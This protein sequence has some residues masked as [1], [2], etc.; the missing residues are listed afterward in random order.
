MLQV[1]DVIL[2]NI[3][4]PAWVFRALLLF[5]AAGLPFV[6]FFAW[7]FELTPE[8]LKRESEVD[9]ITPWA[10]KPKRMLNSP[11]TFSFTVDTGLTRSLKSAPGAMSRIRPS[12]G[13]KWPINSA[14]RDWVCC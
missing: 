3:A 9:R 14:I 10:E 7:A 13:W 4:A 1:S 5:V 2:N 6:L 12:N 8:G 11:H